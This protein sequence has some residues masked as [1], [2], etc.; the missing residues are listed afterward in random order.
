MYRFPPYCQE[1]SRVADFDLDSEKRV[2][3]VFSKA[4]SFVDYVRRALKKLE[5]D[6]SKVSV[7][8]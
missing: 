4:T 5:L 1:V 7:G 2:G 8:L 3:N 6:D